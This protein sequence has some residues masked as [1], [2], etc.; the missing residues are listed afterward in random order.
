L[1]ANTA[2]CAT[3]IAPS[4]QNLK[5][6]DLLSDEVKIA[7]IVQKR[8]FIIN[9]SECDQ[10]IYR[11]SDGYALAAQVEVQ[12]CGFGVD[13]G[14]VRQGKYFLSRKIAVQFAEFILR[15]CPLQ[16][17]VEREYRNAERRF[18]IMHLVK[19]QCLGVLDFFKFVNQDGSV[20]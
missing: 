15:L 9:G 17:L 10:D 1:R 6:R 13:F 19:Q 7:V 16:N 2:I 11:I 12:P 18:R 8:Y 4:S 14:S 20:D 5:I 3:R